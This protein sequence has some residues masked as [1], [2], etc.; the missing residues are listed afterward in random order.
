MPLT[1]LTPQLISVP[2]KRGLDQKSDNLQSGPDALLLAENCTF[3]TVGRLTKRNGNALLIDA[4]LANAFGA[5]VYSSELILPADGQMNTYDSSSRT[6]VPKGAYVP[7]H[8]TKQSVAHSQTGPLVAPDGTTHPEGVQVFAW[9]DSGTSAAMYT[10]IDTAT[11]A[12]L[13]PATS[14]GADTIKPKALTFGN[15]VF[16]CWYDP[17]AAELMALVINPIG[18]VVS[19]PQA[20]TTTLGDSTQIDAAN[21]TYDACIQDV[22]AITRYEVVI[23]NPLAASTVTINGVVFTA[24]ASG[25]GANQFDIGVND[26]ATAINLTAAINASSSPGISG[27]VTASPDN[28]GVVLVG[29]L[30]SVT[31][32]GGYIVFPLPSAVTRLYLAFANAIDSTTILYINSTR[33]QAV[34]GET[35]VVHAP[36]VLSIFPCAGNGAPILAYQRGSGGIVNGV[37]LSADLSGQ[38]IVGGNSVTGVTHEITG[39][40]TA[41]NNASFVIFVAHDDPSFVWAFTHTAPGT[42]LF[43]TAVFTRGVQIAAKCFAYDPNHPDRIAVP[44]SYDTPDQATCF[45]ARYP[46]DAVSGFAPIAKVFPGTA[47]GYPAGGGYGG[48][49]G[50]VILP[51]S[52]GLPGNQFRTALL[53]T[54]FQS[55]S[56]GDLIRRTGVD[57]VLWDMA[58]TIDGFQRAILADTLQTNGGFLWAYDGIQ[59]VEHGFHVWPEGVTGGSPG[60]GG[61]S[62]AG[63]YAAAFIYEWTDNI[64]QIYYSAPSNIVQT[65]LSSD[66]QITYT[67]PTLRITAKQIAAPPV[68]REVQIGCYQTIANGLVLYRVGSV[69]NDPTVDTVTFANATVTDAVLIGNAELYTQPLGPTPVLENIEPPAVGAITLFQNRIFA[70]DSTEPLTLYFSK[71]LVPGNPAEFNDALFISMDPRGGVVTGVFPLDANLIVFKQTSI[72]YIYGRGPD[73]TGQQDGYQEPLLITTDCGCIS[74]KSIVNMPQGLMFQS[75]KGI[76]LLDHNQQ[77]S[78]IG[79]PVRNYARQIATAAVLIPTSNQVRFTLQGGPTLSFDYFLGQW[80]VFMPMNAIDATI[81]SGLWT[82][83][84]NDGYVLQ[85][86]PGLFSDRGQWITLRAVPGRYQFGGIQG[87]Q[88]V[89]WMLVLGQWQSPHKLKI[90]FGFNNN[91][92]QDGLPVFTQD[93]V[94]TPPIPSTYGE[95]SPYGAGTPYGGNAAD[96]QFRFFVGK[97]KTTALYVSI[98][99][100]QIPGMAIGEG[101]SLSS[102]AFNMGVIGGPRRMPAAASFG[103]PVGS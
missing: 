21:P 44:L 80:S 56:G 4:P 95:D 79:A 25:A 40:G 45:L 34:A 63:L 100:E 3:N 14:L 23:N 90:R 28:N 96:Y 17:T 49:Y 20:I 13:I 11:Q 62:S 72:F 27:T 33:P 81:W 71:E 83:V 22:Q 89:W 51:E 43:S 102:L 39:A 15:L 47:G 7:V 73:S 64:G 103:S 10:V 29:S 31:A 37:I 57:A 67:I 1:G 19:T 78:F 91:T 52:Q 12:V 60:G 85:E 92:D 69:P 24:V 75:A 84:D 76:Y 6:P 46:A 35:T 9:E 65:M 82:W 98:E 32:G 53:Q 50:A 97:Q 18:P 87:Y 77:V 54:D 36:N 74:P 41:T 58:D 5:T 101:C 99:D 86:T 70:Q 38:T 55:V 16:L 93:I 42:G 88:R 26:N 61:V 68:N 8:V 30:A 94:M 2:F 66:Q 48:D 59:P